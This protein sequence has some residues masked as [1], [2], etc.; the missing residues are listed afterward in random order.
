MKKHNTLLYPLHEIQRQSC[1]AYFNLFSGPFAFQS[2]A[3]SAMKDYG[4]LTPQIAA[5]AQQ[6]LDATYEMSDRMT[7]DYAKPNFNLPETKIGAAKVAVTEE[8]IEDRAFGTLLHFKRDTD[9]KDPK[10]LI[11]AP[12]S[13]HFATLLRDTVKQLLPHHDVYITDWKDAKEVPLSQGD[14]SFDDYVTYVKDFIKTVGPETHLVAVCQPTVPAIAAVARMAEEKSA[15][16]PISMTLMGG[17]IDTRRA[18]TAVSKLAE[19]KPIEWFQENLIAQVPSNYAGAGRMVYP[20]FVQ[21]SS[22]ISMNLEKHVTSHKELYEFLSKGVTDKADKIKKFYDEYLAVSD[23]PGTFYIETVE[24]VFIDQ[25]LAKGTLT[26]DNHKVNPSAIQNTA[27]FTIE[28][29]N[30]DIAA[31]GQTTAA[32]DLCSGLRFDQ[33]FNYLQKDAGHYGIFSGRHWREEIAPMV[34]GFI[35]DIAKSQGIVYDALPHGI[36]STLPTHHSTKD[37]PPPEL[38]TPRLFA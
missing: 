1:R 5:S 11:V 19:S 38:V 27:M 30:D 16:Q 2:M 24:N 29:E 6:V 12:M 28:G 7:K 26:H 21:L 4:L 35:R 13:G 14:F 10:V 9:R 33:K 20:G 18:E 36:T 8:I 23:L 17:P 25:K 37:I 31:P 22:F 3:L 32:H 34:T 15:F